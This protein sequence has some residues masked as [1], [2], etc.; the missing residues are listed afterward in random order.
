MDRYRRDAGDPTTKARIDQDIADARAA[1]VRSL[2]TVY[3]GA[4]AFVG[5]A[6]STEQLVAAIR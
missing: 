2:P 3:V 5:A 6:A 4:T 1:G